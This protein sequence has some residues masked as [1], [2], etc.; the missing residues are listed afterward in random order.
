MFAQDKEIIDHKIC[1][2]KSKYW[3][4]NHAPLSMFYFLFHF[5]NVLSSVI[6]CPSLSAVQ[7]T[8]SH[9]Q[10]KH[11]HLDT[12]VLSGSVSFP[13]SSVGGETQ[14]YPLAVFHWIRVTAK[15]E[16]VIWTIL[17]LSL[18]LSISLGMCVNAKHILK[19]L[20]GSDTMCLQFRK[21]I[22]IPVDPIYDQELFWK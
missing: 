1:F 22:D 3:L 14:T 8:R 6:C 11:T 15:S 5:F 2:H 12:T 7:H 18:A 13:W 19:I 17:S 4:H 9:T 10:R 16:G 21:L 20:C